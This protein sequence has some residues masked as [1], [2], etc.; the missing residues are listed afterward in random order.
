MRR[1]A[2]LLVVASFATLAGLDAVRLAGQSRE[3]LETRVTAS[4]DFVVLEWSKKHPWDAELLARG[5]SLVAEYR[6]G[7][8][9]GLDCLAQPDRLPTTGPAAPG[10]QPAVR[11]VP[12]V[13]PGCAGG[14]SAMPA[15]K[16]ERRIRFRLPDRV[17]SVPTGPICLMIRLPNQRVLPI[18]QANARGDDTAHFRYQPWETV[19]A[20]GARAAAVDTRN[21]RLQTAISDLQ[22]S[23]ANQQANNAAQ[24]WTSAAKCD[25]LTVSEIGVATHDRPVAP[26]PMH[27]ELARRVCVMRVSD[28]ADQLFEQIVKRGTTDPQ[29][30]L[31]EMAL[32]ALEKNRAQPPAVLAALLRRTPDAANAEW[33]TLRQTQI[34]QYNRD[35]AQWAPRVAEY[36]KQFPVPHFESFSSTLLLQTG[37]SAA[38]ARVAAALKAGQAPSAADVRGFI[39]GSLEAYD[40]CVADGKNQLTVNYQT[41]LELQ[42]TAATLRQR[43]QSETVQECR[44]GFTKLDSLQSELARYQQELDENQRVAPA[45]RAPLPT[46]SVDLN[47]AACTP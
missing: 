44:A 40:R 16:E 46:R 20:N 25:G 32:L 19:V 12:V 14:V 8:G 2:A 21:T 26:P 38:G 36:K 30:A 24:G 18:R 47:D 27:D 28:A 15:G 11:G 34:D 7:A 10:R 29:R 17:A 6:T 3:T 45:T 22:R 13:S 35:W 37:T 4:G 5:A 33:G 1:R 43:V 9:V 31:D 39:G 23:I 42:K 41:S